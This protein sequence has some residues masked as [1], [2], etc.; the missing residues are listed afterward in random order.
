MQWLSSWCVG[1]ICSMARS[2]EDHGKS[3]RPGAEDRGWSSI[4]RVLSGQTIK[5]SGDAMCGLH[6]AQGDEECMFLC[7]ASKPRSTISPGLAYKSVATGFPVLGLK[8]D[9]YGLEICASKSPRRFL[10]L[11]LK[12]KRATVCPLCHKT[13][14]RMKMVRDTHQD[15][16]ACFT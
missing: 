9:S 16:V 1:D 6:H 11:D 15:L 14:G 10:G 8:T 13:D 7:L 4:G 5:R 2:D 3:W 12:T